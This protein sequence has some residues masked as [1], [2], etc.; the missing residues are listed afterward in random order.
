M[1]HASSAFATNYEVVGAAS[2][3]IRECVNLGDGVGGY[4]TFV[5]R[6]GENTQ[7][8]KSYIINQKLIKVT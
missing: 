6:S 8:P 7:F 4:E 2:N 3:V 1:P 5:G